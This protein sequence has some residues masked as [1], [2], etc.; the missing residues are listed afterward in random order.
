MCSPQSDRVVEV[1]VAAALERV[2]EHMESFV[3][4]RLQWPVVDQLA[5]KLS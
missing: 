4:T 3:V 1:S 2:V 5:L